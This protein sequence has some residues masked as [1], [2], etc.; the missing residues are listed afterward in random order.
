MLPAKSALLKLGLWGI[1]AVAVL[2][3]NDIP[4]EVEHGCDGPWG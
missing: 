1:A 2:K 4:C 3:I